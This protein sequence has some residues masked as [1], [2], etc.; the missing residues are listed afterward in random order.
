MLQECVCDL[1]E[2]IKSRPKRCSLF[3]EAEFQRSFTSAKKWFDG[4]LGSCTVKN[5]VSSPLKLGHF[6]LKLN[7]RHEG[8]S[9]PFNGK[10]LT[11]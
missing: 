10:Y 1:S 6:F 4:S 11:L 8:S 5:R 9:L 3:S 2:V 7:Y